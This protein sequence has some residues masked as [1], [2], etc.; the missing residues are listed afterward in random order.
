MAELELPT[1]VDQGTRRD[2]DS[3]A[4]AV[5][6]EALLE[7]SLLHVAA[8]RVLDLSPHLLVLLPQRLNLSV[9]RL[10]DGFMLGSLLRHCLN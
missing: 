10:D 7:D 4:G 3:V 8:V 5:E 9:L 2:A 6:V 1:C